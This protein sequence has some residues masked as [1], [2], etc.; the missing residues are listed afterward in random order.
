[1][2]AFSKK[3]VDE[4]GLKEFAKTIEEMKASGEIKKILDK[5]SLHPGP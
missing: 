1:M 3:K 4:A 5:Y 2:T